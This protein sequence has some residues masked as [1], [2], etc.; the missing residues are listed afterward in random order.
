MIKHV[1]A[2]QDQRDILG[3]ADLVVASLW[4]RIEMLD[5]ECALSRECI[6][7]VGGTTY[8][9][10]PKLVCVNIAVSIVDEIVGARA[11]NVDVAGANLRT[12]RDSM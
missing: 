10:Q 2:F 3:C 7:T 6:Q 1:L 9:S 5:L 12:A 4:P 11:H 8:A